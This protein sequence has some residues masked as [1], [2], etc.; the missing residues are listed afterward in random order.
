MFFAIKTRKKRRRNKNRKRRRKRRRTKRRK[1]T[2][3]GKKRRK[4]RGRGGQSD[5]RAS[6]FKLTDAKR[7][8]LVIS[9]AAANLPLSIRRK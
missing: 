9:K 6:N 2:M 5:T 3:K 8:L 7:E 4:G 1:I